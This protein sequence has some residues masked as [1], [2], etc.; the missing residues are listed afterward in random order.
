MTA[1]NAH[2]LALHRREV[3]H[4]VVLCPHGFL[5]HADDEPVG[6]TGAVTFRSTVDLAVGSEIGGAQK[7]RAGAEERRRRAPWAE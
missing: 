7:R 1:D 6:V 4:A 3:E 5:P 2:E